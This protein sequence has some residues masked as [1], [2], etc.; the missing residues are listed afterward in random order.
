MKKA[1]SLWEAGRMNGRQSIL[2]QGKLAAL[3]ESSQTSQCHTGKL[4][5]AQPGH[6]HFRSVRLNGSCRIRIPVAAKIAFATAGATDGS[7]GSPMPVG[8]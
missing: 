5:S 3:G 2:A 8:G 1:G 7:T 4:H 6:D